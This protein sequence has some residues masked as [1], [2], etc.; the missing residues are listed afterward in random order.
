MSKTLILTSPEN[1]P[2]IK[3]K[4]NFTHQKDEEDKEESWFPTPSRFLF[5]FFNFS[6][7]FKFFKVTLKAKLWVFF[8]ALGCAVTS[9]VVVILAFSIPSPSFY[10]V[11]MKVVA[12]PTFLFMFIGDICGIVGVIFVSKNPFIFKF[13]L[14]F[15][16]FSNHISQMLCGY[17]CEYI[18]WC[19]I[20]ET[21]V[22]FFIFI[23]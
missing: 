23:F 8:P 16:R 12:I 7:Y 15:Y 3:N 20:Y 17:V 11:H 4:N 18:A 14:F 1:S 22:F 21:T 6:L 10:V 5:F 19:S 2:N 9:L 13:L